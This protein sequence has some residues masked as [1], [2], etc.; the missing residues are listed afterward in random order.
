MLSVEDEPSRHT[1]HCHLL[2][3]NTTAD[4]CDQIL[5]AVGEQTKSN[6]NTSQPPAFRPML[7]NKLPTF[8][9]LQQ[10]V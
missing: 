3:H 2:Y 1:P 4:S 10:I 8:S 7:D 9:M 6:V 5:S